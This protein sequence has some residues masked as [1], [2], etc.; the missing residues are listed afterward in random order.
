MRSCH[1][2]NWQEIHVKFQKMSCV[3]PLSWALFFQP[4]FSLSPLATFFA[5]FSINKRWPRVTKPIMVCKIP[6]ILLR[7]FEV[8]VCNKASWLAINFFA[9]TDIRASSCW[10]IHRLLGLIRYQELLVA[11]S[12]WPGTFFTPQ[13]FL[14]SIC[15]YVPATDYNFKFP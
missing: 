10:F 13:V 15:M 7:A 9:L 11:G 12:S 5:W 14:F 2:S 4:W 8:K 1:L 6:C 3:L